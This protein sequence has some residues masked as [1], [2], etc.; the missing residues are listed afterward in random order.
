[1][2]SSF[3]ISTRGAWVCTTD[4]LC[5]AARHLVLSWLIT[6]APDPWACCCTTTKEREREREKA[7]QG[8][9]RSSGK[10]RG[11]T[12]EWGGV[13]VYAATRLRSTGR[14]N[15][16]ERLARRMESLNCPTL[17]VL[18]IIVSSHHKTSTDAAN[19]NIQ[20]YDIKAHF[21]AWKYI[22]ICEVII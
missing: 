9:F 5:S 12:V 16:V 17:Y 11:S 13:W 2:H 4:G 6:A 20:H 1:M 21:W 22:R 14:D 7:H 15:L 3:Y 19:F 10:E 18:S 8:L